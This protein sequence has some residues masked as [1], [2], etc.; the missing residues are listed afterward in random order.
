MAGLDFWIGDWDARWT[1]GRG[2]NVV[3]RDLNGRAVI[4]QFSSIEDSPFLGMSIS[5]EDEQSGAWFQTW[6]DSAGSYWTFTGGPQGDTFVFA[7]ETRVDAEQVYKRMVFFDISQDSF[8]WRWE[9][10][11]DRTVWE[12]KWH[13][14]YRRMART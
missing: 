6:A 2:R 7:T 3:S 13:I 9:F 12:P 4:E 1:G 5:V 10:S 14:D 11:A 8:A